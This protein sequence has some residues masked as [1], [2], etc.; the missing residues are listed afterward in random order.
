MCNRC[1]QFDILERLV[2][3]RASRLSFLFVLLVLVDGSTVL[4]GCKRR[5]QTWVMGVPDVLA[6]EEHRQKV[7][8]PL[9]F[10]AYA[11]RF[12]RAGDH[13]S[14]NYQPPVNDDTWPVVV[15][16]NYVIQNRAREGHRSGVT[17][18]FADCFWIIKLKRPVP[19]DLP[20]REDFGISNKI[21]W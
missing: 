20:K 19:S 11:R 4:R 18:E 10:C 9:G 15:W 17:N 5:I 1:L 6:I 21:R 13:S 3:D 12:V 8:I 7:E 14:I 2:A 16:A